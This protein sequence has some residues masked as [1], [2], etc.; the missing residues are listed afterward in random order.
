[1]RVSNDY[2][3]SEVQSKSVRLQCTAQVSLL[4]VNDGIAEMRR[5]AEMGFRSVFMT[6]KPHPLQKDYHYNDVWEPFWAA[7]EELGMVLAFHIGTDP[8][9]ME[10][11][12]I[13]IQ[14]RGPGGAIL[15]YTE[16]TYSGQRVATKMVASG[17]LDRHPD[18]KI[19]IA[20]GGASWVPSL[21]DRMNEAYRQHA[22]MVNPAL[23]RPPKEILYSQVYT[24][25]QHDETA[26]GAM[27]YYGYDK[28]L[29]GSDY[30]HLEGTYGH[31]QKTLHELFDDVTPEVRERITVGAF[32][33]AI[34]KNADIAGI[35]DYSLGQYKN[36]VSNGQRG[37][38]YS[39]VQTFMARYFA[40]QS[41]EYHVAKYEIGEATTDLLGFL[42]SVAKE[43]AGV[44]T[45]GL[46]ETAA[47][48]LVHGL[49]RGLAEQVP[50]RDVDAA[51]RVRDRAAAP[52]PERHLF[53][54][55]AH[56]F[57]FDGNFADQPGRHQLQCAIYQRLAGVDAAQSGQRRAV[58]RLIRHHLDQRVQVNVWLDLMVPPALGRH[59]AQR[60]RANLFNLHI[61]SPLHL[62]PFSPVHPLHPLHPSPPTIVT[63][64][65]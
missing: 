6:T 57:G 11:T 28:I 43:D 3:M 50:Q 34:A 20:E 26:V 59:P 35:G 10:A 52:L 15:N 53:N 40:D 47:E 17:A 49:A 1:M 32:R 2:A 62:F 60:N 21:G 19:L 44:G 45:E 38:Y 16:T 51:D 4:D 39:G 37:N 42:G 14:F 63:I 55:L 12:E 29:W 64:S 13:G 30:P 23:S 58:H 5:A 41:R 31:T 8:F 24:S 65:R 7:A 22:M 33:D 61:S 18:L 9:D 56:A 27:E 36:S 46:A 48:Q 54:L 25:F